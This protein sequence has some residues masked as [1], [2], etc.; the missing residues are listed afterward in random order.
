MQC[1]GGSPGH[2][3]SQHPP[4]PALHMLSFENFVKSMTPSLLE[5]K[6]KPSFCFAFKI[7]DNMT[8]TNDY[9][10]RNLSKITQKINYLQ[11]GQLVQFKGM[12]IGI[13]KSREFFHK[14]L[15][16]LVFSRNFTRSQ[17]KQIE[18]RHPMANDISR[19]FHVAIVH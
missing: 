8:A 14:K 13:Y 3:T 9:R 17:I 10:L 4:A 19:S 11:L 12:L 6:V 5:L 2:C 15:F 7:P 18:D 1:L 16:G